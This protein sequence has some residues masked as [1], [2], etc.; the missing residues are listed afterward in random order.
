M[1][2]RVQPRW[3]SIVI[4]DT[5]LCYTHTR[6]FTQKQ[7]WGQGPKHTWG[8]DRAP[9]TKNI[10][11]CRGKRDG[12]WRQA[13]LSSVIKRE[14][15]E[16]EKETEREKASYLIGVCARKAAERHLTFGLI[17]TALLRKG[18]LCFSLTHSLYLYI[19]LSLSELIFFPPSSLL[20]SFSTNSFSNL[21]LSV[22]LSISLLHSFLFFS[23]LLSS[24][25]P[26]TLCFLETWWGSSEIEHHEKSV[27][28]ASPTQRGTQWKCITSFFFLHENVTK[29]HNIYN[30]R[31]KERPICQLC[32]HL[33]VRNETSVW[34]I[35]V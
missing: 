31:Q 6:S 9:V 18:T 5:P 22:S 1:D 33:E 14:M 17:Q 20:L 11:K 2:T 30:K 10:K 3:I 26:L 25:I 35:T 29:L 23:I 15:R 16:R 7:T 34:R 27:Q 13:L 28:R 21:S 32:G 19:S 4:S 8:N 24:S 12:R